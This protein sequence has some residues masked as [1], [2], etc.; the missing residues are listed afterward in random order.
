M[1]PPW[2]L[3]P[4]EISKIVRENKHDFRNKACQYNNA[5]SFT[6]VGVSANSLPLET[7]PGKGPVVYRHSGR[8]IHRFVI[9]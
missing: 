2:P 7:L 4:D 5:F 3:P 9:N 6:S 8:M 1:A